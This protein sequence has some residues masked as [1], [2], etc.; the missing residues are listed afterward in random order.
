MFT[1]QIRRETANGFNV[2]MSDSSQLSQA[3]VSSLLQYLK[4]SKIYTDLQNAAQ[5]IAY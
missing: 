1:S 5:V 2:I 3:Y 4:A